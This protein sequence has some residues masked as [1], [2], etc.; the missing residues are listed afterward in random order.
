VSLVLYDAPGP[1]GRMRN[2]LLTVAC[3]LLLLAVAYFVYV[4]FDEKGQWAA[5]KW[6]P[7]LEADVWTT[8]LIPGLEGTLRA[9]ALGGVLALAF[10]VVFGLGRLSEH[11]WIRL[12]AG[13]VV[14]FFRAI[15]LLILIFFAFFGSFAILGVAISAFAA[16]VFGLTL[17][18]GSVIA[19]IVR[20]GVLAVPRGQ[21]EAAYALGLRKNAVMRII[22]LPQAVRSMLPVLIAQLVVLLKDSALGFIIAYVELLRQADQIGTQFGNV[23][24]A[25]IVVAAIYMVINLLLGWVATVIERRSRRAG[26]PVLHADQQAL[27]TVAPGAD[28]VTDRALEAPAAGRPAQGG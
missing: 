19:E 25:C 11:W 14:E 16:V 20:A 4:K 18:N 26:R 23:I 21:S 6:R 22:L 8:Y 5:E 17:Y 27:E 1:R 28:R 15:P 9:A 12:P 7:F 13:A 24:Q 10:G 3:A 2:R